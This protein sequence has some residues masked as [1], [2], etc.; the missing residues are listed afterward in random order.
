MKSMINHPIIPPTDVVNRIRDEVRHPVF[1]N[2]VEREIGLVTAAYRAGADAEL[3]ACCD[4]LSE[5]N[6]NRTPDTLYLTR[7][8]K[9]PSLKDLAL[10][11]LSG[12]EAGL[13]ISQRINLI[14]RAL[15]ALP[16]D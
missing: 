9:Q 13:D 12:V 8:P 7:R 4:W 11:A 10:D 1:C 6:Y 14:R 5:H 15:E 2:A 3:K 16:N